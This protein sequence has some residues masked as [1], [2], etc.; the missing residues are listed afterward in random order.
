MSKDLDSF[1]VTSEDIEG[2]NLAAQDDF[3]ERIAHMY[4][5]VSGIEADSKALL[6][7]LYNLQKH[8]SATSNQG[9]FVCN[10]EDLDFSD[11]YENIEY[12]NSVIRLKLYI[13]IQCTRIII[14]NKPT[15]KVST[16]HSIL[17]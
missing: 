5:E 10:N 4:W 11:E 2:E 7:H 16:T 17:L 6:E 15:V 8:L 9:L 1:S 13:K 14:L 3:H 12:N